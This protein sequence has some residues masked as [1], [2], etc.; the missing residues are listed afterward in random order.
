MAEASPQPASL[1]GDEVTVV[2]KESEDLDEST[3][4]V[5]EV[6]QDNPTS[7]RVVVTLMTKGDQGELATGRAN[8][9]TVFR[10]QTR[11]DAERLLESLVSFSRSSSDDGVSIDTQIKNKV[12]GKE[13]IPIPVK[14]RPSGPVQISG[15]ELDHF[16]RN[17]LS[18]TL[19]SLADLVETN[20]PDTKVLSL[21]IQP[22][23]GGGKTIS[24]SVKMP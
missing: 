11:S 5:F 8:L 3:S 21:D 12:T 13:A 1:P 6:I 14:Q 15:I 19:R 7:N 18:K 16:T 17:D 20:S 4:L 22:V 24:F 23:R 10:R 9:G 2:R